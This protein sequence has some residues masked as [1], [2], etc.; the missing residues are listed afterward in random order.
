MAK[1]DKGAVK[2]VKTEET[3]G[4]AKSGLFVAIVRHGDYHQL[5]DTPSAHQPFALNEEGEF[6]A[7]SGG[8]DIAR[9]IKEN[10][11]DLHT[12]IDSSNLL[13]AWQTA[14]IMAGQIAPQGASFS[15]QGF[16]D[17]A[18]RCVG[19]LANLTTRQ[20]ESI[21]AGDPRFESPPADWKSNSHYQLPTQGAESLLQA[22]ERV[23]RHI[24]RR[25]Q[26]L[27]IEQA[28]SG[29]GLLKVFVGHG[30][31]LRHAA[32]VMGILEFDQIAGLSMY[33]AR[34]VY[35]EYSPDG[36]W[37]QV[38]GEWKVRGLKSSYTD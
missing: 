35:F 21:L 33:H 15:V 8:Q 17:L 1:V 9:F 30:A 14:K 26:Q 11:I 2:A 3:D 32:C 28:A 34:P 31:A 36:E 23:A 27:Q 5:P 25:M 16:D 37:R 7:R 20:I 6:Q 10:R 13:R 24:T 19:S 18:E 22:G 38:D 4:K 29:R 12:E